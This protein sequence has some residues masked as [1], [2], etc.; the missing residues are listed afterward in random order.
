MAL[1]RTLLLSEIG[2]LW[3]DNTKQEITAKKNRDVARLLI[4][5]IT[6]TV[7]PVYVK[8]SLTDKDATGPD[9]L[10]RSI[11]V[12][13][14]KNEKELKVLEKGAWLNVLT[15]KEIREWI[16]SSTLFEGQGY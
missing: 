9:V 11:Q 4:D 10:D 14:G 1:G 5:N 8:N 6:G 12:T 13:I 16:A 7:S 15:E 3:N 2:L